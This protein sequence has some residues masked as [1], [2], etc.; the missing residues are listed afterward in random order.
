MYV[1]ISKDK[2]VELVKNSSSNEQLA[3][4]IADN[5]VIRS[6]EI[7]LLVYDTETH[8]NTEIELDISAKDIEIDSNG[9]IEKILE[10]GI[11]KKD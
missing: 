1:S 3:G 11:L 10:S 5:C 6:S 4:M 2:L 7:S 8:T 9:L